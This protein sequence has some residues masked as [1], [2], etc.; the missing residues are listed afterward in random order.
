MVEEVWAFASQPLDVSQGHD[1]F[2]REVLTVAHLLGGVAVLRAG[3]AYELPT[4]DVPVAPVGRVAEHPFY[5]VAPYHGEKVLRAL[6]EPGDLAP[7]QGADDGVLI[8]LGE[9]EELLTVPLTG[10]GVERA[11]AFPVG[12]LPPEVGTGQSP[13]FLSTPPPPLGHPG[14]L[15]CR[16]RSGPPR[17]RPYPPR[18]GKRT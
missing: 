17:P 18:P 2:F 8:R 9:L 3:K 7:L 14:L 15:R 10:V 16:G 6:A 13:V 12:P 4:Y 5:N 1:R 11:H